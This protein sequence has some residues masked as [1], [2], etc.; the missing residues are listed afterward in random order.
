MRR[1][2]T[3]GTLPPNILDMLK[4]LVISALLL[5]SIGSLLA[6]EAEFDTDFMQAVEDTNKS[7][8]SN[9]AMQDGK[10]SSADAKELEGMFAQVVAFY[11]SK[12]NADDAVAISKRSKELAGEIIKLVAIKDFDNATLKATELSRQCKSCHN[13]YKKS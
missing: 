12:G 1:A 7:L 2:N 13:F 6:S 5:L 4:S 10:G 8:A 11:L 3:R 9:V